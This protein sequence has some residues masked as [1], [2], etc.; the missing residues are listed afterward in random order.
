V[1][2]IAGTVAVAFWLVILAGMWFFQR[3]GRL[4]FV[5]L[6]GVALVTSPFIPRYSFSTLPSHV[7]TIWLFMLLLTVCDRRYVLSTTGA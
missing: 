5:V 7:V 1:S 3:W 6:L 4:I 2:L